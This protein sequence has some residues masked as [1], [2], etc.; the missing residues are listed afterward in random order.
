MRNAKRAGIIA[1]EG[2]YTRA[3]QALTSSGMAE[4]DRATVKQMREKHPPAQH[5]IGPL[6]TTDTAPLSLT[7][8]AVL[9]AATRFKKGTA[10]GPSGLRPEHL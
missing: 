5:P 9:K 4:P 8:E 7:T 2:Q 1:G 3:L 6:P 10:A